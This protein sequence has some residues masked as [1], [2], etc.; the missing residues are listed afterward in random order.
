M[1]N[2]GN[3]FCSEVEKSEQTICDLENPFCKERSPIEYYNFQRSFQQDEIKCRCSN[4]D[5]VTGDDFCEQCNMF[6]Y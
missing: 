2:K 1:K 3:D 5:L 6:I 4:Q